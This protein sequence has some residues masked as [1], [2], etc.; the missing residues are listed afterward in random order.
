MEI[1]D[2]MKKFPLFHGFPV[3]YTVFI[4][5]DGIPDFKVVH[6]VRRI[7]A[8]NKNLCALCGERMSAPYAFI[9]GPQC[10]NHHH[11]IDG[12]MHVE[13]ATYA[14]VTC[15]YLSSVNH[16]HSKKPAKSDTPTVT[17]YKNVQFGRPDCMGLALTNSYKVVKLQGKTQ[18]K[19]GAW[20]SIDWDIMPKRE[21]K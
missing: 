7:E 12:P 10:M 1:P 2:R 8:L 13:C 20:I 4:G 5:D 16:G 11:F 3:H 6:E 21:Q 9:G 18:V 17:E 19:A 15:P 14:A